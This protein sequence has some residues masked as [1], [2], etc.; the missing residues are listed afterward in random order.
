MSLAP[1][2]S[3]SC[4]LSTPKSLSILLKAGDLNESLEC[5]TASTAWEEWCASSTYSPSLQPRTL[6][7]CPILIVT[8]CFVSLSSRSLILHWLRGKLTNSR[9]RQHPF[10]LRVC[11]LFHDKQPEH[12]IRKHVWIVCW[13][14]VVGSVWE[15]VARAYQWLLA[16]RLVGIYALRKTRCFRFTHS[17]Y[18]NIPISWNAKSASRNLKVIYT[19]RFRLF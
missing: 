5:S 15:T 11:P 2:I 6:S 9:Y 19:R 7:R 8:I 16:S 10:S 17:A 14:H 1:F 13:K 12:T 18:F 4:V 3:R